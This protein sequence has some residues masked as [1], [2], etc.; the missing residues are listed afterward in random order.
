V[1]SPCEATAGHPITIPF[2]LSSAARRLRSFLRCAPACP[3]DCSIIITC[4]VYCD[5]NLL[6]RGSAESPPAASAYQR[7]TTYEVLPTRTAL[8]I[9]FVP[10]TALLSLQICCRCTLAILAAE[11]GLSILY[12][13]P[14]SA[15][16]MHRYSRRTH[17]M[18]AR[19]AT[20]A[21]T[22]MTCISHKAQHCPSGCGPWSV[23]RQTIRLPFQSSLLRPRGP[24]VTA[25]PFCACVTHNR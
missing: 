7:P 18:E 4:T 1:I 8:S 14:G 11:A 24:A 17:L 19:D 22:T 15:A 23:I 2:D 9:Y 25:S 16:W 6:G 10:S 21:N 13:C 12:H 5:H 3:N 20:F